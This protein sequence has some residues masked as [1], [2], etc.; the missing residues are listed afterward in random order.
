MAEPSTWLSDTQATVI[1]GMNRGR[2]PALITEHQ[3]HY[4]RN[5]TTRGGRLRSR[6]RF[7]RRAILPNGLLQG[8]T[9]FS[10]LGR[11]LVSVGGRI[12]E[13]NPTANWSS[14]E[15]TGAE[16]NSPKQP[17]VWFCETAGSLVIQDGQARPFLYDGAVFRRSADD[18]V[19]VG[20]AMAY[21]NGRLAVAVNDANAVRLGD[22]RQPEHQSELKFTETNFLTGGGDFSFPKVTA[23]A[24]LPIVDTASGHGSLIVGCRNSVHSLKTQVTQRDMWSEI[25][26]STVILPNR[27][28]SGPN[29]VVAVNQDLFF[30]SSDG[31]RSVR[32]STADYGAPGLA[33]LSVEVRHRLDRDTPSLLTDASVASFDNRLLATHSP[34]FY[35]PRSMAQGIVAMNF[36]TL[37]GRGQKSAPCF[38]GEWDGILIA[39]IV[40]GD[41]A[42]NERCFALG[43]DVA[44]QNTLW[45]IMPD[46][47]EPAGDEPVQV[48]ESRTLFA[49]SPGTLKALRRCDLQFSGIRG[50]LVARVYFRPDN[51]PFWIRWDDFTV[52]PRTP[53]AGD[54]WVRGRAQHRAFLTTRTAP[55]GLDPATGRPRSVAPGF[56]VRIEWEGF[57][58]LDYFQV[59]Q[60]RVE[61]PAYAD[62]APAGASA[63][64]T[65]PADSI[66]PAFWHTHP[67]SP[68]AGIAG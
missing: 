25:G 38:D 5:V 66:E 41:I 68:L 56:Q 8:A 58:R 34:F 13:L 53:A 67:V 60:E 51:H 17:R 2:E 20:Q 54:S 47:A 1:D 36:D 11:I 62:N 16:V 37:S 52:T 46:T 40:T 33:P 27:G 10:A 48:V 14:T 28:I 26:F 55:D 19:P 23:L 39:Q 65:M 18:E 9:V 42:G 59:W 63:D 45:E 32:T 29:A 24:V 30:R 49:D 21:G 3:A 12:H 43:R 22:I 44:G 15:K 64:N 57:A 50:G 35:G 4:L 6:P 7:V 31:L 61:M